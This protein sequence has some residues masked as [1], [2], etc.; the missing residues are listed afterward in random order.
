MARTV[1]HIL[2]EFLIPTTVYDGNTN[3]RNTNYIKRLKKSKILSCPKGWI[4]KDQ[5]PTWKNIY[6]Y[7]YIFYYKYEI[8]SSKYMTYISARKSSIFHT[9]IFFSLHL[10]ITQRNKIFLD[11]RRYGRFYRKPE[12]A[13]T[14]RIIEFEE[15]N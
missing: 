7:T 3:L 12:I 8:Y 14:Q 2:I 9:N 10:L 4:Q 1:S 6:L 11:S 15:S 13:Y 5:D